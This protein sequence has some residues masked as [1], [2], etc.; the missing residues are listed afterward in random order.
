M[1]QQKLVLQEIA[2]AALGIRRSLALWAR[3]SLSSSVEATIGLSA[4]VHSTSTAT[5]VITT[6][7]TGSALCV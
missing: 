6:S 7:T 4:Q 1:E 2:Q 3:L 5:L